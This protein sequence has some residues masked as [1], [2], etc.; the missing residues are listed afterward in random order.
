MK[1]MLQNVMKCVTK[2]YEITLMKNW[3]N[4]R[5]VIKNNHNYGKI[6]YETYYK[7]YYKMTAMKFPMILKISDDLR[8][9]KLFSRFLEMSDN[10]QDF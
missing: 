2:C 6:C 3:E 5:S 8:Y 7:I 1:N 9:Y 4:R 10:V